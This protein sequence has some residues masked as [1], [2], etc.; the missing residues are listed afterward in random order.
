MRNPLNSW[1]RSDSDFTDPANPIIGEK[2]MKLAQ[3]LIKGGSEH[4]KFLRQIFVSV[5]ITA[6]TYWWSEMD[7]YKV[8][9]VANST[10]TMHTLAS[11]PIT[12]NCFELGDFNEYIENVSIEPPFNLV[13]VSNAAQDWIDFLEDLRQAYNSTKDKRFWKEL[14]RWLPRGWL[15]KRTVTLSYENLL[16]MYAQR[17]NHKLTEWSGEADSFCSWVATLPYSKQLI[18]L[19]K[20]EKFHQISMDEYLKN[21]EDGVNNA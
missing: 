10:S 11:T 7:T 2:D 14:V 15:Q 20:D 21:Q 1:S 3:K 16:S 9:T 13:K 8:G 12:L 6:P 17:K 19:E 4:R 5:D 18:T